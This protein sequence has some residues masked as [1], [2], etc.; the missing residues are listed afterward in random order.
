MNRPMATRAVVLDVGGVLAHNM[1]EPMLDDLAQRYHLDRE[2]MQQTGLLLWETFAY[3]GES[4]ANTWR[5]MEQRY[6]RLFLRMCDV[7]LSVEQLIELTDRYVVPMPGMRPL[8][9]QLRARNTRLVICSN[10]NEIWWPRQAKA[11]ELDR[12]FSPQNIILS[13]RIGAPKESPRL[14]MF[15]A[16]VAAAGAPAPACF[17]VDDRPAIVERALAF[18]LDAVLFR[19]PDAFADE[20]RKRALL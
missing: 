8:L 19:G 17:Y 15:R 14:E 9:E 11:L 16:A 2:E 5:D 12:F 10:N 18:G 7:P 3:V 1:W 6:W 20:L 13:S 4:P